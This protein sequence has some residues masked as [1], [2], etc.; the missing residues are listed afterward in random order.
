MG[1]N[2]YY[3]QENQWP[4]ASAN[5][6]WINWAQQYNNGD[7]KN[8]EM[9][10]R[11]WAEWN[12]D[13]FKMPPPSPSPDNTQSPGAPPLPPGSYESFQRYN[14]PPPPPPTTSYQRF[15]VPPPPPPSHKP[16][17][18][19]GQRF[20]V[21][22]PPQHSPTKSDYQRHSNQQ[23]ATSSP[24]SNRS[25]GQSP[26]MY[27]Y[28]N[29]RY[30]NQSEHMSPHQSYYKRTGSESGE[31]ETGRPKKK[32]KQ[33]QK[34]QEIKFKVE[35]CE[36]ALALEKRL[37]TTSKN[38]L[39]IRFPDFEITRD[40]VMDYDRS[41]ISGV[42][43]PSP[44]SP[45]IC[46][47]SLN[48]DADAD[49]V[50]KRINSIKPVGAV[51]YLKADYKLNKSNE[52]DDDIDPLTLYVGNLT[53]EITKEELV[54][55]FPHHRRIDIGWAKKMKFT[56]YAFVSFNTI[57][58][59]LK[60]FENTFN[61]IMHGK[62]LILRFKRFKGTNGQPGEAKP[63]NGQD[64]TPQKVDDAS[65][66]HHDT[67]H[68]DGESLC[69]EK[70]VTVDTTIDISQVKQEPPEY[71]YADSEYED[72]PF[73]SGSVDDVFD[74]IK[75]SF[76]SGIVKKEKTEDGEGE[77]T[78]TKEKE[79]GQKSEVENNGNSDKVVAK[80]EK[81]DSPSIDVLPI[82][83]KKELLAEPEKSR[84]TVEKPNESKEDHSPG[85]NIKK[86]GEEDDEDE[87]DGLDD[88]LLNFEERLQ[89]LN[90]YTEKVKTIRDETNQKKKSLGLNR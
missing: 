12:Q 73:L 54:K 37:E 26:G 72:P 30:N 33:A 29:R 84:A 60:A 42:Y 57:E 65:S 15:N 66:D 27:P 6:S 34:A 5:R 7:Y 3:S 36:K 64:K 51:D 46:F 45:R 44:I 55:M 40:M 21:P 31:M 24:F 11:Q 4:N 2:Y 76:T 74:K 1:D 19:A 83:I 69:S 70:S 41:S 71:D 48:P 90:Q 47:L 52:R 18:E 10:S 82:M 75:E 85:I 16:E 13:R 56:R 59:S 9:T 77:D 68:S 80:K 88:A 25:F 58:D 78:T 38:S 14:Q 20:T 22:P 89:Q 50:I 43:F 62:S 28:Y 81:S 63:Q 79:S 8:Y 53:Q 32:K 35:D 49:A 61:K 23:S 39:I 17:A 67:E 87:D 86:E